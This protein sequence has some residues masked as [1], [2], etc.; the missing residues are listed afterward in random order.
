MAQQFNNAGTKKAVMEDKDSI[1]KKFDKLTATEKSTGEPT[2]SPNLR[3]A[4]LISR[5]I[6]S[7]AYESMVA[8]CCDEDVAGDKANDKMVGLRKRKDD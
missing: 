3:N 1:K 2:F 6:N 5:D 8:S 4:E 7:Q